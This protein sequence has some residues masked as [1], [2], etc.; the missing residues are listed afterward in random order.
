MKKQNSDEGTYFWKFLNRYFACHPPTPVIFKIFFAENF[1]SH[2]FFGVLTPQE[3]K[4]DGA[5]LMKY[6][7]CGN[8]N[9]FL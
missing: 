2:F 4:I 8:L 3:S 1:P 5:Y 6:T 9:N 7:V